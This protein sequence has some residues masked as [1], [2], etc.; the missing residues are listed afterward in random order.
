M[1][2]SK[3]Q[4]K[5]VHKYVKLNY[6]RIEL[7]VPKGRKEAIKA[8][9]YALGQSVNSFINSAIDRMMDRDTS[10]APQLPRSQKYELGDGYL[11]A[12]VLEVAKKAVKGHGV[13][14]SDFIKDAVISY[15]K[16]F[17]GIMKLK[18]MEAEL[19]AAQ[20]EAKKRVGVKEPEE[21]EK[22][23]ESFSNLSTGE[24]V[25]KFMQGRTY[26]A[27]RESAW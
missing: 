18:R 4:Q 25:E 24:V 7:T 5:A 13:E 12:E 8:S 6:D 3:S 11:T 15:A 21:P 19:Y 17:D 16:S 1:T 14:L 9:A 23:E 2:V 10:A 27:A 26:K 22:Q 20:E